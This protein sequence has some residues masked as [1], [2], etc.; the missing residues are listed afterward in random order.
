MRMRLSLSQSC[1]FHPHSFNLST[2]ITVQTGNLRQGPSIG[3]TMSPQVSFRISIAPQFLDSHLTPLHKSPLRLTKML[4]VPL[5]RSNRLRCIKRRRNLK[6][7]NP[8]M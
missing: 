1:N 6:L 8:A 7:S 5:K 4:L 3:T 2:E